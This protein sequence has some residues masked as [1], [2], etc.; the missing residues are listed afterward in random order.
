MSERRSVVSD[1]LRLHGL[2]SPWNPPGQNPGVGCHSLLQGLFLTQGL[3]LGHLWLLHWLAGSSFS[4]SP[5]NR[6]LTLKPPIPGILV[7]PL[8]AAL[9]EDIRAHVPQ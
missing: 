7:L 3:S 6:T 8:W 4:A 9:M 2:Y 5:A 1:S